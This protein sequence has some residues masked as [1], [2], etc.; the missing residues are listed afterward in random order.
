MGRA[1]CAD[2]ARAVDGK[3]NGQVL[4]GD[5]VHQLVVGALEEGGINGDDGLH[6]FASQTAGKGNGVLLG[7][8]DIEIAVG[9]L[10]FEFDQ[11]AALAHG[12]GNRRQSGICRRLV[13][14]PLAE[15]LR[16]G[17]FGGGLVFFFRRRCGF[18]VV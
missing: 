5:V 15:Y 2:D 11:S 18:E 10:L 17:R 12:G 6:A 9:K 13:A 4:Q 1:V 8:A 16:I 3:Q 7:D 14:Q